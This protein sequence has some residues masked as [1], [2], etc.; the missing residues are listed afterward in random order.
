MYAVIATPKGSANDAIPKTGRDAFNE[1][2]IE[3]LKRNFQKG[4]DVPAGTSW[5]TRRFAPPFS[6]ISFENQFRLVIC[7]VKLPHLPD[8]AFIE[9]TD[10]TLLPS[11]NTWRTTSALLATALTSGI[12]P[13]ESRQLSR[14]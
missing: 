3:F 4:G 14:H 8:Q 10:G 13:S 1:L 9:K 12:A 5:Q 7:N 2:T 6:E 11:M